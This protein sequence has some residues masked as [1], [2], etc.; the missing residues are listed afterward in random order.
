[1][2]AWQAALL[3]VVQ[4]LTEFFPVSS[5]GHL[6]LAQSL[7]GV[8]PPGV[9][10]EAVV[11]LATLAAVLWVYRRRVAELARGVLGGDREA[12][13]YVGLLALASI[14]AGVVGLTGREFF[15]ATF[16]R[17][18]V[19]ATLL[20]VSGLFAWSLR[21]TAP[22]SDE[23]TPGVVQAIGIGAAQAMAILPGIS[24]SGAT[25]AVGVASGVRPVRMAEF[26]F[27]LSVPAIAGAGLLEA[28]AVSRAAA[29]G[30][31]ALGVGF[32]AALVSG[33][34]AIRLFVRALEMGA[35]HRFGYYCWAVGGAYLL[36]AWW[37]PGL[38]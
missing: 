31:A 11:H 7:L 21:W 26:S 12:L 20:L 30:G 32:L 5:S 15:E 36:A 27:L 4:G 33:V 38:P 9:A 22:E 14:P 17:P 35:F 2:S 10:F 19:A 25:V 13:I 29:S 16:E 3:G 1:M 37:L 24:R 18:L 28:G 23:E 6:V 34:L 8:Q